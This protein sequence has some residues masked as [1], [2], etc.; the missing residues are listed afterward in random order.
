[1]KI[2]RILRHRTPVWLACG[3]AVTAALAAALTPATPAHAATALSG[4]GS[5]WS[6]PALD[7]WRRD[8]LPQ[9]INI[10]FASNGSAAGRQDW[11]NGLDDF[12]ASDVPFRTTPDQG[13]SVGGHAG[14]QGNIENPAWRYSY[15][16]VTAGGTTFMY[17]LKIGGKQV[18]NLRL[19]PDVLVG[20]FTNQITMW[21]DPRIKAD[22]PGNLPHEPITPVVRSDGSGATAQWTRYME[23]THAAQWDAYCMAINGVTCGDY[24]EFFPTPP[25]SNMHSENGSDVVASFIMSPQGEGAIG[26]DEYA[27]AKLNNWPVV[28]VLNPAGYYT[29]PTA[30]NVAIALTA[31]KIRGVDDN[32]PPSDPNY[33]Q[34]NLDGVY[35]MTDPR[36]YP[37]SSYSYIIVPRDTG[38]LP[39]LPRASDDHGAALSKYASYILCGGQAEADQLGYSPIPR[40]LVK[41]GMLQVSHIPGQQSGVDPNTL[42]NCPNPTFNASGQ[43]T[44]LADAPQPSPCDKAG[45]ALN[46]TVGGGTTGGGSTGGTTGGSSGGKKGRTTGGH[47]TSGGTSGGSNGGS[48]SIGGTAGGTGGTTGGAAG[49][50]T[51]GTTGGGAGG[52]DPV[53]GQSLDDS[54]GGDSGG[55][56]GGATQVVADV[57]QHR[58]PKLMAGLTALELLAVVTIPP[59]LGNM[60]V[61]RRRLAAANAADRGDSEPKQ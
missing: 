26:Y 34:Q 3:L 56:S 5:S 51:G 42:S 58:D 16:P 25:T 20:I 10:N 6:G 44:V 37:I 49:G 40:N 55:S 8:I 9:G 2:A 31:A 15:V 46:C 45:T 41:G 39:A 12:T 57:P 50:T 24:T 14:G 54:S 47:S 59:M 32:T 52:I 61:R 28:K 36:S 48:G 60:L 18:T 22:Y 19:S 4:S 11:I 35:T 30:S 23:H 27:Y 33:L 53:T 29:V 43:L 17:N 7:Q 38:T 13:V 21:D 1:M